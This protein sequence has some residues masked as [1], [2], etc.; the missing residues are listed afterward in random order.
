MAKGIQFITKEGF[1]MM[2]AQ[3][4]SEEIVI[5]YKKEV[6]RLSQYLPW[7]QSKKAEKV[8]DFYKDNGLEQTSLPIPVFDGTLLKFVKEAKEMELMDDNYVYV[9]SRFSI[10]NYKD[11][12]KLIEEC[13]IHD[14]YI[15]RGILSK[16]V[17]KGFTKSRVWPEAMEYMIFLKIVSK[18]KEL[19]EFWNGEK[20]DGR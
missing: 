9:Y 8:M 2:E 13:K 3:L 16:Y 6:D 1:Y 14:I 12:W 11:E 20:R 7:L 17:L 4:K 5:M 19:M 10:R 15:L 18:L